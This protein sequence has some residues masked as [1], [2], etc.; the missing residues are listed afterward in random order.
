[1][2][3]P[4]ITGASKWV[5]NPLTPISLHQ[6]QVEVTLRQFLEI[7]ACAPARGDRSVGNPRRH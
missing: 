6:L 4:E 3:S 2:P 5:G 1:M 7:V